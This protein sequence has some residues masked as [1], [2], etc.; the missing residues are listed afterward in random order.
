MSWNKEVRPAI[1]RNCISILKSI[2]A[3]RCYPKCNKFVIVA[4]NRVCQECGH[5]KK[6][7]ID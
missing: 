4:S 6:I 3:M 7:K 2:G 5:I 1:I